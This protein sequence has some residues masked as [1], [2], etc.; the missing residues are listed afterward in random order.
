MLGSLLSLVTTIIAFVVALFIL[1]SLHELGHF[2][3][4]RLCGIKVLRFSIGFGKPF[5]SRKK[6]DTEWALAPIPLGGYVKMVDTRE[7]E[8]AP[9]DLPFA[10]DKQHPAKRIAVVVAGP[11]TNLL[12]AVFLFTI[13]FSM[14]I[15]ELKPVVGTVEPNS[16]ASRAGFLPGDTIKSINNEEIKEWGDAH[17][18]LVFLSNK[19][20]NITVANSEGVSRN[21]L[22]DVKKESAA[23]EE[24]PIKLDIGIS[25][26][27]ITFNIKEITKG[28][29]ADKAGLREND[30]IIALNGVPV[31]DWYSWKKTI[32][33]LPGAPL[34]VTYERDHKQTVQTVY[35]DS[36]KQSDG[37]LIGKIGVALA[38]DKAWRKQNSTEYK[39]SVPQAFVLA[40]QKTYE[41]SHLTLSFFGK[42]LTGQASFKHVSGPVVIAD[43]AGKTAKDGLKSYISFLALVSVSLGI[44]NLLPIPILDG[45]HLLY[46]T[47]EWIRGKPLSLRVQEMGFRFGLAT[48]LCLMLL[49]FFNDF[50]RYFG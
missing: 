24:L 27:K 3:V 20:L 34:A 32:A 15:T 45:G 1:V 18:A 12:L 9:E 19:N 40:N 38:L 11:L 35:L 26:D 28:S 4:A 39:P 10:F 13:A 44:L 8:V 48:M 41:I 42:M 21:L 31:T 25:P 49:A 23:I 47:V 17:S 22:V 30:K 6:G 7:G 37:K 5:W 2:T 33:D 36:E 43:I 50:T 14:G 16:I 29:P 46:Y